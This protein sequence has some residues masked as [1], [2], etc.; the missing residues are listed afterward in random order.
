MVDLS[1]IP[2]VLN[3]FGS[4]YSG[5]ITLSGGVV[6]IAG[7]LFGIWRYS[8][9]RHTKIILVNKQKELDEARARLKK[10]DKYVDDGLKK[11]L[12]AG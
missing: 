8:R 6:G 12:I 3:K 1:A 7:F 11:Y 9:E 4:A 2:E 10:I 5:L